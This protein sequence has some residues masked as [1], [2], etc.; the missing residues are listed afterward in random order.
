[1]EYSL[2]LLKTI[3]IPLSV[4]LIIRSFILMKSA[5]NFEEIVSGEEYFSVISC[6]NNLI[7]ILLGKIVFINGIVH[8]KSK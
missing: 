2:L 1:M 7:F 5:C 6:P 3:Q 4:T 8:P